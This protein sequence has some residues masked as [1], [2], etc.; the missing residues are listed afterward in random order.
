MKTAE[1]LTGIGFQSFLSLQLN[2][3]IQ[4]KLNFT[5]A[6]VISALLQADI[7]SNCRK[8][9]IESS[10]LQS[11]KHFRSFYEWLLWQNCHAISASC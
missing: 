6:E 2:S 3:S 5:D 4:L 8:E 1:S 11:W 10:K 7:S 9:S